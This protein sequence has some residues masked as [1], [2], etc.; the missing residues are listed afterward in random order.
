MK[1]LQIEFIK[2]TRRS[3]FWVTLGIFL[4]FCG[5]ILAVITQTDG[6]ITMNN[7]KISGL[8]LPD[9]WLMSLNSIFRTFSSVFYVPVT[10][11]LLTTGEFTYKTARQNVIDGLSKEEFFAAKLVMVLL[12]AVIYLVFYFLL[13]LGFGL[14]G[15]NISELKESLVRWKDVELFALYLVVLFGYGSLA[16]LASLVTR[17]S[18]TAIAL[19][20][21]YSLVVENIAALLLTLKDVTKPF[22]KFLPT[23]VFDE[24][25]NPLRFDADKLKQSQEQLD[26]VKTQLE[27]MRQ[28]LSPDQLK[29]AETYISQLTMSM[30][31]ETLVALGIA[32]VYIAVI[33]GGAYLIFKKRDL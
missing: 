25:L 22:V 26:A 4:A 8:T 31:A 19:F 13:T 30:P 1:L 17:S 10:I 28:S 16:F 29:S 18:G 6:G 9:G 32:A 21:F 14:K 23:K 7:Q 20:L 3:A 2:A 11:I 33:C 24:L 15:T 5:L 12:V 27:T